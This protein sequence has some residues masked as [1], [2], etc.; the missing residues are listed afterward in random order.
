M[1]TSTSVNPQSSL[2]VAVDLSVC[3]LD[4]AL[5]GLLVPNYRFRKP[6]VQVGHILDEARHLIVGG[7][8][9][10]GGGGRGEGSEA[11]G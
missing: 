11:K 10:G 1:A 5:W 7:D 6:S 4:L 3:R 2:D 8:G 9:S